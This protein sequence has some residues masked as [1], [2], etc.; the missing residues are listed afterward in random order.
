MNGNCVCISGY[1]EING[2]CIK[3]CPE[4]SFDNGLGECVC[5]EGFYKATT[6]ICV[7]G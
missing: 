5:N 7:P 3:Q 1:T 2:I 6:G 4:N